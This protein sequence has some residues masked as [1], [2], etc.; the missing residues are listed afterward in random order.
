VY[1]QSPSAVRT[2]TAG[3]VDVEPLQDEVS[4]AEHR[5]SPD[6]CTSRDIDLT[7]LVADALTKFRTR[8]PHRKAPQ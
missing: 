5:R 2:A 1:E 7:R 8:S 3:D 6:V 4:T